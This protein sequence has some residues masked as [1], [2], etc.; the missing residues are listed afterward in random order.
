M[1]HIVTKYNITG[2]IDGAI[3]RARAYSVYKRIVLH[4]TIVARGFDQEPTRVT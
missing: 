4:R 3:R 2:G 1:Q